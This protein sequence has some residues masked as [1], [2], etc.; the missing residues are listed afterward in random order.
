MVRMPPQPP[1][2]W[3][4]SEQNTIP[5]TAQTKNHPGVMRAMSFAT[6]G[7]IYW[8]LRNPEAEQFLRASCFSQSMPAKRQ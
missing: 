1:L 8:L 5:A 4:D 7:D 2:Y 3:I 6:G